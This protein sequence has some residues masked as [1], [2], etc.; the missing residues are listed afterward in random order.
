VLRSHSSHWFGCAK[1][2]AKNRSQLFV[3]WTPEPFPLFYRTCIEYIPISPN[4]KKH[5]IYGPGFDD[6]SKAA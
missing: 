4:E 3:V 5:I 2:R 1:R 6:E